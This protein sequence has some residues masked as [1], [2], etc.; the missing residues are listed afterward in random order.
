VL[1]HELQYTITSG[2][3]FALCVIDSLFHFVCPVELMVRCSVPPFT[4][5]L[6]FRAHQART[7]LEG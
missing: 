5:V 4:H 6:S 2:T 1:L 3:T 7:V